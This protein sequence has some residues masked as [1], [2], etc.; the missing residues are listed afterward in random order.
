MS[1][2]G[3]IFG[4][5]VGLQGNT[6]AIPT[7]Q[8]RWNIPLAHLSSFQSVSLWYYMLKERFRSGVQE[9]IFSLS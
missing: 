3:A 8:G 2:F 6:D 1:R 4:Q 5:G 7:M 9:G